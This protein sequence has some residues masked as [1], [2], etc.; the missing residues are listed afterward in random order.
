MRKIIHID[1]D[2]FFAAVEQRDNPAWRGKPLIVGGGFHKRDVVS[3]CSYEARKFGVHSAMPGSMARRLCPHGI[4][5]PVNMSKYTAV[6]KQVNSIFHEFT[7]LVEPMSLDEAY[8]DVSNNKTNCPSATIIAKMIRQ[9]IQEVTALTA[10]AGVSYNKFIA[11]IAS[12]IN[13]PDGLT[14]ILPSEAQAFLDDLPVGKFF[15]IGKV[16]A[17]ILNNIGIKYGRDLKRKFEDFALN[18]SLAGMN[19]MQILHYKPNFL[20][21]LPLNNAPAFFKIFLVSFEITPSCS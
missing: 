11:K 7:D 4:F 21:F 5:T 12:D 19:L 14:V 10:S 2:A 8:L 6:S 15:G 13:K 18:L 17:N 1:M 20:R 16:T 3:T 9:R